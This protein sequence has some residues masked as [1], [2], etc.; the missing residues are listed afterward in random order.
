MSFL[1]VS[2][3]GA[4]VNV[5]DLGIVIPAATPNIVLSNQFHIN[6]LIKS[7]DLEALIQ[8]STLTVD[9]DYGTGFQAVA[10]GD[11]T[12]RDAIGAFLNIFE[13]T[14]KDDNERLVGA[15]DASSGSELHN[16]DTKYY[17][18]TQTNAAGMA[19]NVG[20]DPANFQSISGTQLQQVLDSIDDQLTGAV[21]LDAVYD[22]DTDGIMALDGISKN[23][24]IESN[25][26]NEFKVTRKI[27]VDKQNLIR[28]DLVGNEVE[29]GSPAVG[30]LGAVS[31]RIRGD[32]NVEGN[33]NLTGVINRE[34]VNE[35][36][37]EDASILLRKNAITD[38][39]AQVAVSRPVAGVDAS[40]LWDESAD[41]WKA[42]LEGSEQTIA[43]LEANETVSGMWLHQ[44]PG[45]TSPSM[46]L[47]EKAAAPSA[48]LG[49]A[50]QIP[51]AVINGILCVYDKT[52]S[53]NKF[54]SVARQFMTFVG[55]DSA[56]NS[57]E[58][59]RAAGQFTSNQAGIRLIKNATL[60]GISIQTSGAETWNARV[61]RNGNTTNLASLAAS[62]ANGAQV[63]NLNIDFNAGDDIEV[64][65]DGTGINRPVI[66]LEFADRF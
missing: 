32:L 31:A 66:Q 33:L 59:A 37:V 46:W 14:N 64:F 52:N 62:A 21:N 12:H 5:P 41:R 44:G 30:A 10:A 2:N 29:I 27:G 11:Y 18:K 23:L 60:V 4:A 48:N 51:M 36:E 25:G 38:A 19:A 1:R 57:N 50:G 58:Y 13:V 15:G 61:R 39:N 24:D 47:S 53:R 49:A 55:R 42:G 17:T 16:H 63:S 43:L 40:L 34:T 8:A 20:V 3:A 65:I 45:A 28:T 22:N 7:A 54:L 35:L 56:L 26:S 6:E 9:I